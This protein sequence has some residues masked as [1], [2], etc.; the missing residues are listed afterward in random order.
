MLSVSILLMIQI[1][2]AL[3][4]YMALTLYWEKRLEIKKNI[5]KE[6]ELMGIGVEEAHKFLVC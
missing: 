2:F 6:F 4:T 1:N 5:V 3:L